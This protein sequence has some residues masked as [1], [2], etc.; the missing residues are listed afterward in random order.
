[1]L[2]SIV[3]KMPW[4]SDFTISHE[5]PGSV[6]VIDSSNGTDTCASVNAAFQKLI[7]IAIEKDIFSIIHG[8][9]S[10]KF[11][12]PGANYPV[13]IERFTTN[14]FGTCSRGAHMTAYVQTPEGIKIWV[15][16]RSANVFTYPNMLDTT[17]AGGVKATD[18]P[19]ECII[20][21]AD[22]EASLPADLVKRD[23]RPCGVLTYLGR[24]DRGSGGEQGL[25]TPDITYAYDLELSSDIIPKPHDD[26]V[27]EFYLWDVAT[28][29]AALLRG[30]F[31]TNCALIM[32]DFFMRHGI[33]TA[34]NEK[35]Y[36][37]IAM[38]MHRRLP[39][40]TA[41]EDEDNGR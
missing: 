13:H 8:Q 28:V 37:E 30:E 15:P 17:V 10:E 41:P 29:K 14:L 11:S 22:E 3:E 27:K 33:I 5:H 35:D 31:K 20:A 23:A 24:S 38:R 7:D 25:L 12:I 6:Q 40:P 16:R 9:H 18:T 36:V 32:V 1:M 4:T 26:E 21:E 34:D 39:F 2:P 19:F